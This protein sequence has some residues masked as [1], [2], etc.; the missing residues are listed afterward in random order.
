MDGNNVVLIIR[1]EKREEE[2]EGE[3][4]KIDL[5]LDCGQ[6]LGLI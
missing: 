2:E 5:S 3:E 6:C 1:R 4:V